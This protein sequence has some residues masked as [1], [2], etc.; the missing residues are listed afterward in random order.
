MHAGSPI[1]QSG[2][3]NPGKHHMYE[4]VSA[5]DKVHKSAE[6]AARRN[7]LIEALGGRSDYR[8]RAFHFSPTLPLF[9]FERRGVRGIRGIG[10]RARPYTAR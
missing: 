2:R 7:L 5:V 10:S 6:T 1:N 9:K 3:T 4:L 8:E